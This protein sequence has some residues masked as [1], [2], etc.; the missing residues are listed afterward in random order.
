MQDFIKKFK[1][2]QVNPNMKKEVCLA[3]NFIS[4][5]ELKDAF[6]RMEHGENFKQ[7]DIVVQLAWLLNGFISLCKERDLNCRIFCNMVSSQKMA[8]D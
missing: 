1:D 4:I 5:G 2:L 8:I 3:I 6:N 7:K